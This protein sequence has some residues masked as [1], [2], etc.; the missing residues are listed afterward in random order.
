M[1]DRECILNYCIQYG[2]II[3][4]LLTGFLY[5]TTTIAKIPSQNCYKQ[6]HWMTVI[7][8]FLDVIEILGLYKL[9]GEAQ[10]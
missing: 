8:A 4:F 6:E 10:L 2:K 1:H 5:T 7:E 9:T 3:A